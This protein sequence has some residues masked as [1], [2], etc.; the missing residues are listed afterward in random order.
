MDE[1]HVFNGQTLIGRYELHASE[2]VLGRA[3]HVV[4]DSIHVSRIHALLNYYPDRGY[5]VT[6]LGSR[7][8][9][10]VNGEEVGSHAMHSLKH[11]DVI[12]IAEFS[13]RCHFSGEGA[14]MRAPPLV[15][16]EGLADT[17]AFDSMSVFLKAAAASASMVADHPAV[18]AVSDRLP[19][20]AFKPPEPPPP[21]VAA[22][23]TAPAP[24]KREA[25]GAEVRK[26]YDQYFKRLRRLAR[27]GAEPGRPDARPINTDLT[28]PARRNSWRR[29]LRLSWLVA[30]LVSVAW[31]GTVFARG[32]RQV[33]TSESVSEGHRTFGNTH[34]EKCHTDAFTL[35]VKDV[36]CLACHQGLLTKPQLEELLSARETRWST[37]HTNEKGTPA[38]GSCHVEHG[39]HP[40]LAHAVTDVQCTVC[41][42]DLVAHVSSGAL[43]V[44]TSAGGAIASLA[45]HDEFIPVAKGVDEGTLK[46]DHKTHL[47]H[48]VA[49][50]ECHEPDADRRYMKPIRYEEH[51]KRCHPIGIVKDA[52]A[53]PVPVPHGVP[54]SVLVDHVKSLGIEAEMQKAFEEH[55]AAHPEELA[56]APPRRG[57]PGSQ[58]KAEKQTPE[59]WVQKRMDRWRERGVAGIVDD[60]LHAESK[61]G[62]AKC[63]RLDPPD[64]A[65]IVAPTRV[66]A[67]WLER[68][69]FDHGKHQVVSCLECHPNARTST[70]TKDVL[71][72]GIENCRGCHGPGNAHDS[73]LTCHVYHFRGNERRDMN[74][75][76]PRSE[77]VSP[78]ARTP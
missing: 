43:A 73:C 30:A 26:V 29:A 42:A 11:T 23:P 74:G 68:G 10:K 24:A 51:C 54:A 67:R 7:N 75:R 65:P 66:P 32:H 28:Y 70:E 64:D 35:A 61:Q 49:C 3:G 16:R 77:L 50:G 21:P 56:A 46:L 8:G 31:V 60:L 44:V 76:V 45:H 14:M 5:V 22:K 27:E 2:L 17:A 52:G 63:H 55:I 38:C 62:C 37:H 58:P 20:Q 4:L 13:L 18:R 40:L 71:I 53:A 1:L 15:P 41:H 59:Q 48:N 36:A 9:V 25:V 33:F 34:C 19:K 57:P 12:E 39:G 72:P 69:S 47:E 6:D 78:P